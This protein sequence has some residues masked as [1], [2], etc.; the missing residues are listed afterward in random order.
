MRMRFGRR[1]AGGRLVAGCAVA[2]SVVATTI[3]ANTRW[4]KI[5]ALMTV[6]ILGNAERTV[7]LK[8][9][10]NRRPTTLWNPWIFG[11]G[12]FPATELTFHFTGLS[13]L[14]SAHGRE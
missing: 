3:N 10:L 5:L 8:E 1:G 12:K 2:D 6:R 7:Q 11:L 4:E 13:P 9:L 14:F